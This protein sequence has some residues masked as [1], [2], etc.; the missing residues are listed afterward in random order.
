[1]CNNNTESQPNQDFLS[2]V[3]VLLVYLKQMCLNIKSLQLIYKSLILLEQLIEI[4]KLFLSL[5]KYLN[6]ICLVN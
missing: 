2:L 1:M 5:K 6:N 3:I 4:A